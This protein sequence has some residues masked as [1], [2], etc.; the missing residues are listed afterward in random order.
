MFLL[1]SCLS[2]TDPENKQITDQAQKTN[3]K[4][5]ERSVFLIEGHSKHKLLGNPPH[6]QILYL[7]KKWL[8]PVPKLE[9][10]SEIASKNAV[11]RSNP[12]DRC[13]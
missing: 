8:Y 9:S 5:H 13:S 6:I 3:I 1:F 11:D 7:V 2:G 12:S 4:D 10:A